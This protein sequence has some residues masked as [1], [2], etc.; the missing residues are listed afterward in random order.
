MLKKCYR[1]LSGAMLIALAAG[2][3]Q[4]TYRPLHGQTPEQVDQDVATCDFKAATAAAAARQDQWAIAAQRV[5]SAC[6]QTK[7]YEETPI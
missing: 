6:M 4:P 1:A 3:A 2:C 5:F 7:G